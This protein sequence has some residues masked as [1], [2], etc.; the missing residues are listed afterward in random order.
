M[1]PSA[2]ALDPARPHII[3]PG[4]L[5]PNA[6]H[7]ARRARDVPGREPVAGVRC[8]RLKMPRQDRLHL[9][10]ADLA[11]GHLGPAERIADAVAFTHNDKGNLMDESAKTTTDI[12]DQQPCHDLVCRDGSMTLKTKIVAEAGKCF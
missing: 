3:R 11:L 9:P 5:R 8:P 1:L 6:H 10:G 2:P 4:K 12:L 7:S